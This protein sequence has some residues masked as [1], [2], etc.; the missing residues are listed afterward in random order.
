MSVTVIIAPTEVDPLNAIVPAGGQVVCYN[1][2]TSAHD[3]EANPD[4]AYASCPELNLG[5]VQ[6]DA[7]IIAT[8]GPGAKT[9]AYLDRNN[10]G[11]P[12]WRGTVTVTVA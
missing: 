11:N 5:P 2:T 12:A 1:G 10:P 3:I 7:T 8:V 9:C 6:S 4:P